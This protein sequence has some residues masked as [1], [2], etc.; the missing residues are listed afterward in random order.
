M[1]GDGDG[2]FL[3]SERNRNAKHGTH[4]VLGVALVLALAAFATAPIA[5]LLDPDEGYYPATAAESLRAGDFWDLRFNDAPRW[6]KPVLSYALI[7]AAFVAFGESESAARLPS[8]IEGVI[9]LLVIGLSVSRIAGSRAGALCSLVAGTSIAFSIFARVAH[10][11]I[12]V[13]LSIVTTD[14]LVC[15]WLAS[16]DAAPAQAPRRRCRCVACVR[17]AFEGPGRCR[18][19][20]ARV[21]RRC[22]LCVETDRNPTIGP[23]CTAGDVC[24]VRP[25]RP[26]VCRDDVPSRIGVPV[27]VALAAERR[28]VFR[29]RVWTSIRFALARVADVDRA[30]AVDRAPACSVSTSAMAA[31]H[32]ERSSAALH[33]AQRCHGVRLLLVVQFQVA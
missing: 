4:V 18:P 25:C 23:T 24:R 3:E 9:L 5:P 27:R 1:H 29:S 2:G 22:A 21:S 26:L 33:V 20:S 32:S 13:V 11:E 30:V 19:T 16:P 17:H 10:P 15:L 7:A 28:A 31:S 14:L 8:A 12:G 6:D